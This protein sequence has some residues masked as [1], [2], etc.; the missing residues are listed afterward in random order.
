MPKQIPCTLPS[1]EGEWIEMRP[2]ISIGQWHQ[3][4]TDNTYEGTQRMVLDFVSNWTIT[5][6]DG[7]PAPKTSDGVKA[8]DALDVET[9]PWLLRAIQDEILDRMTLHPQT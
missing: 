8:L 1:H 7:Q 2:K 3:W 9:W 6:A 5:G 4:R